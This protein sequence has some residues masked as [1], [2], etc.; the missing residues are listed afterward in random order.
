MDGGWH[1]GDD[2]VVGDVLMVMVERW[3]GCVLFS[4]V[5]QGLEEE[6]YAGSAATIAPI[7]SGKRCAKLS[8]Y[9]FLQSHATLADI[10]ADSTTRVW[11]KLEAYHDARDRPR[12]WS[13]RIPKS[14]TLSMLCL[15]SANRSY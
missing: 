15:K 14:L 13:T 12:D 7:A 9:G 4:E 1:G 11:R 10:I 2:G 8:R 6:G 3:F 5:G